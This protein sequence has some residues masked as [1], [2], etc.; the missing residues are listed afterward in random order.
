MT[1]TLKNT[2][3]EARD[4]ITSY[5]KGDRSR[6]AVQTLRVPDDVDVKAVR[7]ELGLSQ[8]QFCDLFGFNLATLQSW[9]RKVNRRKPTRSARVLITALHRSPGAILGALVEH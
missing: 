9:E 8:K 1:D 6:V 3:R 2:I 5:I 4:E 7:V